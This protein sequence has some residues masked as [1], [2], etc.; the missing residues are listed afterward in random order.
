MEHYHPSAIVVGTNVNAL[1]LV[2]SLGRK[3]IKVFVLAANPT[4]SSFAA[5]SK[6][7]H[8]RTTDNGLGGQPLIDLLVE[9]GTSLSEKAA[10]FCTTDTSVLT[11]SQQRKKLEDYFHFVLPSHSVIT[12]LMSKKVFF[13]FAVKNELLV[14][15]TLFTQNEN[16]VKRAATKISYPCLIKP[17][18]RDES[19]F[20]SVSGTDKVLLPAW[21]DTNKQ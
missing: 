20:S 12:T 4:P 10:L 13:D 9:I 8:L 3:G 15:R 11:V 2:R 14:P 21:E 5:R 16:D 19:W 7:A 1:E 17:E 18:Y 6:Y